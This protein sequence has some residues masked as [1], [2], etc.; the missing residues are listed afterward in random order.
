METPTLARTTGYG[1][2]V[3]RPV[4]PRVGS[5]GST[6]DPGSAERRA[7][8][9]FGRYVDA[10]GDLRGASVR[11]RR[12]VV[13]ALRALAPAID[14]TACVAP[15]D[16]YGRRVL[17]EDP[18]GW[19]LAAITLRYG[20][21]TEAHDHDGWGG[22]VTVQGVERDRRYGQDEDGKLRL[23]AE[24]DFPSGTGYVFD[25][26]D[27]HQPV[28]VARRRLTIALHFLVHDHGSSQHRHED[29]AHDT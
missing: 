19:S 14:V 18:A 15:S 21:Q 7:V 4:T 3:A 1:D 24:R 5:Y 16:R 26:S 2:S 27:I 10:L 20:Q 9:A 28:G 23:I 17:R 29:W 12:A 25:A 8:A 6:G 22:V 11:T 13:R